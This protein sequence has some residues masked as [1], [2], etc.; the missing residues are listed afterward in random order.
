[1][2]AHHWIIVEKA[3]GERSTNIK[4]RKTERKKEIKKD[5]QTFIGTKE[6]NEEEMSSLNIYSWARSRGSQRDVVYL[7]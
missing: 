7:G 2:F 6:I 3:R 5:G 4:E 1:V